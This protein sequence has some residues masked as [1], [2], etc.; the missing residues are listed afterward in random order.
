MIYRI[1][2]MKFKYNFFDYNLRKRNYEWQSR[3]FYVSNF[4]QLEI[5]STYV[6]FISQ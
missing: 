1:N 2:I 3:C 4:L 6:L 5:F